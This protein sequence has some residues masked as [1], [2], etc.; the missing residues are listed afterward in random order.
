MIGAW[1]MNAANKTIV[2][3]RDVTFSY[4]AHIVLEN[5]GL[6]VKKGD[7]LGIIGPNGAG[8]TTLVRLMLGLLRPDRGIV[9]LFGSP[10]TSADA[11]AGVGYVPQKATSFDQH[12]PATVSEVVGMGRIQRAGLLKQLGQADRDAI[13]KALEE[14]G[15]AE[16]GKMRVS[17][18]SGGQQ[19]R[20][21]IARALAAEP[22]LL[23]LD[24]PT[25]GVDHHAQAKFYSILKR[26]NRA[27]M[28]IVLISHDVGVVS[29]HVNKLACVNRSVVIHDVSKGVERAD[30]VCAYS[31]GMKVVKHENAGCTGHCHGKEV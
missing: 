4:G 11:R 10:A 27:G 19:Q 3:L 31:E 26:L 28:A 23:I 16:Y 18:L 13:E 8:K 12:F 20:V 21:F 22:K 29:S 24:E 30:L 7:F 25:V 1:N 15:M 17:E 5:A 14:V 9:Q 2:L 6:E